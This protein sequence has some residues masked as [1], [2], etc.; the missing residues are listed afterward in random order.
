MKLILAHILLLLQGCRHPRFEEETYLVE[1]NDVLLPTHVRT[2]TVC[3]QT[4][5]TPGEPA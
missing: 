1:D 3:R 2:C 5:I 4:T